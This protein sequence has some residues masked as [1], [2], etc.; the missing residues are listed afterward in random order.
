[1]FYPDPEVFDAESSFDLSL[2]FDKTKLL[3]RGF[4]DADTKPIKIHLSFLH[5]KL[6]CSILGNICIAV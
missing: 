1:L 2:M 4:T 5:W 3:V 6:P